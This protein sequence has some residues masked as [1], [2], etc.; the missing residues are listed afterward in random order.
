MGVDTERRRSRLGNEISSSSSRGFD[1]AMF[2]NR[3]NPLSH[4]W[5]NLKKKWWKFANQF[6]NALLVLVILSRSYKLPYTLS[7]AAI[8]FFQ[9]MNWFRKEYLMLSG[10]TRMAFI[11]ISSQISFQKRLKSHIVKQRSRRD[12]SPIW[13]S[14]RCLLALQ[15]HNRSVTARRSLP[16]LQTDERGRNRWIFDRNESE[17]HCGL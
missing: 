13:A 3:S 16:V 17:E 6:L 12:L 7:Q 5:N 9:N 8:W 1:F 15:S 11:S 14:E 2:S 10:P 4:H